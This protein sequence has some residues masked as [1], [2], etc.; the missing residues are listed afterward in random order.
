MTG[1]F[2]ASSEAARHMTS[3]AIEEPPGLS[4]RRTTAFTWESSLSALSVSAIEYEPSRSIP[5]S[6][7]WEE[8]PSTMSPST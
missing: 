8:R 4:I 6:G 7:M 1:F 2:F 3:A 5:R